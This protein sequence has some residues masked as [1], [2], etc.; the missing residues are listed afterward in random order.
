MYFL[1]SSEKCQICSQPLSGC[2]FCT[3]QSSCLSCG[4]GYFMNGSNLC[5]ACTDLTGCLVCKDSST[6]L[7]CDTGYY[8][9]GSYTCSSCSIISGCYSCISS[10]VCTSCIGG[11][12]LNTNSGCDV[13]TVQAIA[14]T[15]DLI[16]KTFYVD[17]S[18][19]K[20]Y[21]Y[22][23]DMTF[24]KANLDWAANVKLHIMANNGTQYNLVLKSVEWSTEND[25]TIIFYTDNPINYD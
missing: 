13:T 9:T 5:Q 11:Y 8:L 4:S 25:Y 10:S 23:K 19:L 17:S 12:T 3:N 18:T 7:F 20:H 21:L 24:T 15:N 22:A 14:P 6:C 1:N 2:V 16:L